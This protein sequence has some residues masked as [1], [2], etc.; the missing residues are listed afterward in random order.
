[1]NIKSNLWR[2]TE[3][4]IS[5]DFLFLPLLAYELWFKQIIFELDSLRDLF[6]QEN[7]EESNTLEI[8]K[9]LNRIVLIL[10]VS[11][12]FHL[13]SW[14]PAAF[15]WRKTDLLWLLKSIPNRASNYQILRFKH[16][17]VMIPHEHDTHDSEKNFLS[18]SR[19]TKRSHRNEQAITFTSLHILTSIAVSTANQR[20]KKCF[21]CADLSS[22][23]ISSKICF[24]AYKL[25]TN[26]RKHFEK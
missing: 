14:P 9:R 26:T 24:F 6:N 18:I 20:K 15:L 23:R 21:D 22:H 19:G 7:I 25:I 10:N 12:L 4:L 11:L 13:P 17:L 2:F 16:W 3:N 1:M 5:V 8:L